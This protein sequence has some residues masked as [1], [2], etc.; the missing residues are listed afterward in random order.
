MKALNAHKKC[1]LKRIKDPNA[2]KRY[3]CE[4]EGCHY[5]ANRAYNLKIHVKRR[6]LDL[7]EYKCSA[8]GCGKRFVTKWHLRR[9]AKQHSQQSERHLSP[10]MRSNRYRCPEQDCRQHYAH[11]SGLRRHRRISHSTERPHRC[12][13]PACEAA[14]TLKHSLTLHVARHTAGRD[15]KCPV[16]GCDK[17]FI[18][19]KSL[20]NHKRKQHDLPFACDYPDCGLRF[21]S[22]SELTAH[23][24]RHEGAV[25]PFT[26]I[27]DGCG[28]N[29][30]SNFVL[31]RH[32][33]KCKHKV[34]TR[35]ATN[36][37]IVDQNKIQ[38]YVYIADTNEW[39]TRE[40]AVVVNEEK[41]LEVE[42][43]EDNSLPV[44]D[45]VN[46]EQIIKTDIGSDGCVDNT[47]YK[48]EIELETGDTDCKPI[49]TDG[50][51]ATTNTD[52][53]TTVWPLITEIV[54]INHSFVDRFSTQEEECLDATK[55]RIIREEVVVVNEVES[56]KELSAVEKTAPVLG[57]LFAEKRF[58]ISGLRANGSAAEAN[59][60]PKSA[61]NS[62]YKCGWIGCRQTF[63]LAGLLAV[64]QRLSHGSVAQ[65]ASEATVST[66]SAVQQPIQR[67]GRLRDYRLTHLA[68]HTGRCSDDIQDS[69]TTPKLSTSVP[70][71]ECGHQFANEMALKTHMKSHPEPNPVAEPVAKPMAKPMVKPKTKRFRCEHK[72]CP[73]ETDRRF[74]F[75]QHQRRHSNIRPVYKCETI[76]CSMSFLSRNAMR[77]HMLAK[78]GVGPRPV[79]YRCDHTGCA[80]ESQMALAFTQHQ[81]IH[82]KTTGGPKRYQCEYEG[83]DYETSVERD[84]VYHQKSRHLKLRYHCDYEGCHYGTD[85]AKN[86]KRHEKCC[87][88]NLKEYKCSADGCGKRYTTQSALKKHSEQHKSAAER[89]PIPKRVPNKKYECPEEGC[90]YK[91]EAPSQLA[92]HRA[93]RHNS[94]RPH[95][96]DYADCAY[97]SHDK[98]ALTA[99][100]KIHPKTAGQP[101]RYQ[102]EYEGCHYGTDCQ[103][104]LKYHQNRRHL[105]LKK[106]KCL[107]D[108]CGKWF[109]T[110]YERRK[111]AK[112][113]HSEPSE[114]H[115][116]PRMPS[117]R[118]LCPERDCGQ[119]CVNASAL[120][121]HQKSQHSAERPH[122]C[123]WPACEAAFKWKHS[124]QL[125]VSKHTGSQ[126]LECPVEGCGKRFANS[127][128]LCGHKRTAHDLPHACDWPDCGQRFGTR[129]QWTAHHNR[130]EGVRP[131][132]CPHVG[133]GQ[134]FFNEK[135][136]NRHKLK[137]NH[138]VL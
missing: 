84:F 53:T 112:R 2:P 58:K 52:N 93:N 136:L 49:I 137:F 120:K 30:F 95:R 14:F 59:A 39:T 109:A 65:P 79:T 104:F 91:C 76:G 36:Q 22:L 127:H 34:I 74:L 78:H 3:H 108:G 77:L 1:H 45:I 18:D 48:K 82:L 13:W 86:L 111:H 85:Y 80:Y 57:Q 118:Y 135:S 117:K 42:S 75:G 113:I 70:C 47:Y 43:T 23:H 131:F 7:K 61:N 67:L 4:Y 132:A 121:R 133:C 41:E 50:D 122:R 128:A 125:H 16:D 124:L 66:A 89:K 69:H 130:H 15:L 103:R 71:G 25:R 44:E 116:P 114:R 29:F 110:N 115:F 90:G 107:A 6:H 68:S 99:H 105:N 55:E 11:P 20:Y 129:Q 62:Q 56:V 31:R 12:D 24:K 28:R 40:E 97:E 60:T 51:D 37:S 10:H 81:K 63:R 33:M 126:E 87:H 64:H 123:D 102:C 46:E 5:G 54:A 19:S 100:K 119:Y 134:S 72:D 21:A 27:H 106:F 32:Q 138:N 9:H 92:N 35:V 98:I 17:R 101:K 88:L 94:E 26:C 96:C 8:D 73:Y 83:C 38:E